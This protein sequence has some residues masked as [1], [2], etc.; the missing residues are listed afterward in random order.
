MIRCY[1]LSGAYARAVHFINSNKL[2]T[3]SK[4]FFYYLL[5]CQVQLKDWTS[6][7]H[8][9]LDYENG[10]I[11]PYLDEIGDGPDLEILLESRI[12]HL[13]AK[14][15]EALEQRETAS[16]YYCTAVCK[17]T[18]IFAFFTPILF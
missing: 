7:K 2:Q 4:Q 17:Y 14:A 13:K 18:K 5:Y 6:A 10:L 11:G 3:K 15:F 12:E 16:E 8:S 1:V 9:L